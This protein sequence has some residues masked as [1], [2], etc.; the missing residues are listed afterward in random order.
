MHWAVWVDWQVTTV[1][2]ARDRKL[3]RW[4]NGMRTKAK[5]KRAD[6][7]ESRGFDMRSSFVIEILLFLYIV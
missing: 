3:S 7:V 5:P 2:R 6:V 4:E 1:G